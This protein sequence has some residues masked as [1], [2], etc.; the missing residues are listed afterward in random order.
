MAIKV[1]HSPVEGVFK[2]SQQAGIAQQMA[3]EQQQND[4]LQLQALDQNFKMKQMQFMEQQQTEA[5]AEEM[6]YQQLLMQTKRG[7]DMQTEAA[8]YARQKQMMTQTLNMIND[9]QEFDDEQKEKLKIQAMSKYA[10]VGSGISPTSFRDSGMENLATKGAYNKQR[11][12]AMQDRVNRD[13]TYTIEDAQRD[14][15]AFGMPGAQ[16]Y[17]PEESANLPA[18]KIRK[19]MD[20]IADQIAATKVMRDE[21]DDLLIGGHVIDKDSV[22]AQTFIA[23]ER[24]MKKQVN[25]LNKIQGIINTT[26]EAGQELTLENFFE[27]KVKGNRDLTRSAQLYGLKGTFE[28]YMRLNKRK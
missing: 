6:Q 16:F 9:S 27:E 3:R 15:L 7:I 1:G 8:Q 20:G 4:R 26:D 12:D 24:E 10:G 19:R 11:L 28:D 22:Q 5:R 25:E 21:D 14:S 23:L 17:T 2:L 13:P 18:T